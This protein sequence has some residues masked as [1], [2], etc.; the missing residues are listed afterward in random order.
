MADAAERLVNLALYLAAAREPVTAEQVRARVEGY[1]GDQDDAAFYRMFE[2][3]KKDLRA[4]GLHIDVLERGL[5]EAY[6][7]DAASS[8]ASPVE[9][10]AEERASLVAVGSAMRE[11]PSFP[12]AADLRLALAKIMVDGASTDGA[13]ASALLADEAP[14]SQGSAVTKLV[15]GAERRKRVTFSYT[16]ATGVPTDREIEPY[17]VFLRDGRWYLVGAD[18]ARVSSSTPES[19]DAV[20]VFAVIRMAKLKVDTTRAEHPD[21]ERPANFDAAVYARMPF[22]FGPPIANAVVRFAPGEAWRA[23]RLTLGQGEL[24]HQTDGSTTWTI[25]V[26]DGDGLLRWVVENGPGVSVE[27]PADL[28]TRL[29]A[30]LQEVI[31]RHGG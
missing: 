31:A 8:F 14:V 5:G 9:L 19:A 1:P 11:D 30:G 7:L 2:R 28:R 21:F 18:T 17:G 12:F 13:R 29:Q 4:A 10:S 24:V 23:E 26:A 25:E 22:Q 15:E 20:R 16:S 27:S 3:D 6:R